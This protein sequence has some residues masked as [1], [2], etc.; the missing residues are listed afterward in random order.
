[1]LALL[2]QWYCDVCDEIIEKPEDGYVIWL[3]DEDLLCSDFKIIHRSKC[4]IDRF[5][6]TSSMPLTSFLEEDGRSYLMTFL[7]LGPVKYA[8]SEDFKRI[9]NMNEFADFFRRVQ[10]PYYEEAR[11]RFNN[12]KL[13]R[14]FDDA[15]EYYPYQVNIL[16][17]IIERYSEE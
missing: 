11:R 13:L 5:R 3:M 16:K 2:K 15:N 1:M 8:N 12:E 7:S 6:Y 9:K 10:V 14:D 4:D 17:E